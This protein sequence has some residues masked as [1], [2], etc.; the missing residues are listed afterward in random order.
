MKHREAIKRKI[1]AYLT[2]H[3][4]ITNFYLVG[5]AL[6][7]ALPLTLTAYNRQWIP[8]SSCL[9]ILMTSLVYHTTKNPLVMKIDIAA[10]YY[11]AAAC[12]PYAW[13]YKVLYIG[14]PPSIYSCIIYHVGYY[15]KSMAW[16]PSYE[17]ATFWHST[18][19]LSVALSILW[20]SYLIG[21]VES[22]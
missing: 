21:P 13:I 8:Y 4:T 3:R 6:T 11:L 18:I 9:I 15:T 20:G 19:H 10:C 12:I 17:E 1:D 5:S 2:P 16:S 22:A 14:L 7:F